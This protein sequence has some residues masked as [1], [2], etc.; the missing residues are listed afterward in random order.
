MKPKATFQQAGERKLDGWALRLMMYYLAFLR[1]DAEEMRE[2]VEW[3]TGRP[4]QNEDVL[5]SAQSDTEAYY[6]HMRKARDFSRAGG[7]VSAACWRQGNGSSLAG[8][9]GTAGRRDWQLGTSAPGGCDRAHDEFRQRR[10][11]N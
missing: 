7:G 6:G 3:A 2:Q 9:R 5:L 10:R 1:G 4:Q 11:R 8:G